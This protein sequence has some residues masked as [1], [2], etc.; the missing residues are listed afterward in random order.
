MLTEI[1]S[2]ETMPKNNRKMAKGQRFIIGA[3]GIKKRQ[4]GK[5]QGAEETKGQG[6]LK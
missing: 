6:D 4:R 1:V 3:L 2:P 5:R